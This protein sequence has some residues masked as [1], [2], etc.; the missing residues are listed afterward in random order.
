MTNGVWSGQPSLSTGTTDESVY[1][2][3]D[4]GSDGNKTNGSSFTLNLN[5][6][7]ITTVSGNYDYGE[8]SWDTLTT[9]GG[10]G[11]GGLSQTEYN[12]SNSSTVVS[13]DSWTPIDGGTET[14]LNE[15]GEI[16]DYH[17]IAPFWN[18]LGGPGTAPGQEKDGAGPTW[19]EPDGLVTT[20]G[21]NFPGDGAPVTPSG[22][23]SQVSLTSPSPVAP[24]GFGVAVLPGS[25]PA[26][27]NENSPS[28]GNATP[29]SL[30][31][32]AA[33]VTVES[34][35]LGMAFTADRRRRRPWPRA[36]RP[37]RRRSSLRRRCARE[38]RSRPQQRGCG[39]SCH[40]HSASELSLQRR[41][42]RQSGCGRR[43]EWK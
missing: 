14:S 36:T 26:A 35:V 3:S 20:G 42:G 11:S 16:N 23:P 41:F 38:G 21:L 1:A 39:R 25:I 5:D 17:Y 24:A 4:S 22:G 37:V 29:S 12:N 7:E 32:L 27:G 9:Y 31:G 10:S 15:N 30:V 19:S 13:S 6:D 33:S 28:L 2:Y 34:P 43:G 18:D 40:G 8:G